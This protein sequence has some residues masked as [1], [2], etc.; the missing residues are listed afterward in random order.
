MPKL[1]QKFNEKCD[2]ISIKRQR[3]RLNGFNAKYWFSIKLKARL[4][5]RIQP[6]IIV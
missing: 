2:F 4:N 3:F 1:W 6:K 5:S